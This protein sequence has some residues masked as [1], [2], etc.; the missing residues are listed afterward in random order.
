[1]VKIASASGISS[2][3]NKYTIQRGHSHN[4]WNSPSESWLVIDR[5]AYQKAFYMYIHIEF[6]T[7]HVLDC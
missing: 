3:S 1:M 6:A 4:Q 2:P 7:Q 5:P